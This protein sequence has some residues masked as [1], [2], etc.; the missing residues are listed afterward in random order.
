MD[1]YWCRTTL[2]Y[3]DWAGDEIDRLIGAAD[4]T[5]LEYP[6][7]RYYAIP[8]V[9]EAKRRRDKIRIL[10]AVIAA[11]VAISEGRKPP[12]WPEFDENLMMELRDEM[13][14]RRKAKSEA[15]SPLPVPV[16]PRGTPIGVARKTPR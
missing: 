13:L 14:A 2:Y 5:N 3:D 4:K 9:L 1:G 10:K 15:I 7:S 12:E 16:I 8:R 6:G 11:R